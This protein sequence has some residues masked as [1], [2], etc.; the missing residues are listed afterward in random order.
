MKPAILKLVLSVFVFFSFVNLGRAETLWYNGDY[1]GRTSVSNY[2]FSD[3]W[4]RAGYDDF[5]VPAGGW[6]VNKAWA[7]VFFEA[8]GGLTPVMQAQWEI[9]S[10]V[11]SGNGGTLVASGINNATLSYISSV[12]DPNDPSWQHIEYLLEVAGLDV[13]LSAGNYWL[14]VR[15]VMLGEND[16]WWL[17][18]TSGQNA[19]GTPPGNNDSA[20]VAGYNAYPWG[21][22]STNFQPMSDLY[23]W[24]TVDFSMGLGRNDTNGST[25]VPEPSTLLTLM[26]GMFG[27]PFLKRKA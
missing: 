1:D 8:G 21:P 2:Y 24:G 25:V 27:L 26:L 22:S 7:N 20:Y 18:S 23:T 15:P 6:T 10:G 9:R 4:R 3:T 17:G 13:P 5:N 14:N 16:G 19:V 12:G 11:S